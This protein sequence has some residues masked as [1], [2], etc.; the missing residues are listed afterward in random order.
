MSQAWKVGCRAYPLGAVEN[1]S[2]ETADC[3]GGF[4]AGSAWRQGAEWGVS[5]QE[6]LGAWL[7][8]A[9]LLEVDSMGSDGSR[10]EQGSGVS[11]PASRRHHALCSFTVI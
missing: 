2:G 10:G 5:T 3:D 7:G 9:A 8:W 4:G 11:L 1:G 6:G